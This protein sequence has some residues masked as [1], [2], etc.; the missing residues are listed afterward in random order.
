MWH[1]IPL[2]LCPALLYVVQS[3]SA[4]VWY[5]DK[6][7]T[8]E[9]EDGTSWATA[10]TMIQPGIDAAFGDGGGDVWVAE[11]IY[12]GAGVVVAMKA[13]VHIY[14]GFSGSEDNRDARNWNRFRTN[15][16][17]EESARCVHGSD[18]ATLDGFSIVNG[19]GTDGRGGSRILCVK[20]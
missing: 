15:I 20:P 19:F 6:D 17:G 5:V 12:S 4:A 3:A 9:T 14:G 2:L 1:K 7:N 10:F 8:S 16:D 11:G 13:N 18:N